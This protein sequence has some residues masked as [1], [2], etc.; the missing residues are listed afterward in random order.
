M[1]DFNGVV[2]DDEPIHLELYQKVLAPY[3]IQLTQEAYY[4][5]YLPLDSHDCL[6]QIFKDHREPCQDKMIRDLV[7][8]KNSLYDEWI[9][10]HA[11]LFPG[12][13]TFIAEAAA[14]FP[15]AIV[16]GATEN[17]IGTILTRFNL[18]KHFI[19]LI[20][21]E[22]VTQG[23]PN[24]EGLTLALQKI[25]HHLAQK[26]PAPAPIQP[27]ECC[28]IEDSIDGIQMIHTAQM[29]CLSITNSYSREKLI[30]ADLILD[31]LEKNEN[32]SPLSLILDH[33]N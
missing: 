31:S 10:T 8:Q 19:T 4:E 15:L 33:F 29:N 17:E 2:I 18:R 5:K 14:Q 20:S 13:E 7:H 25:N 32:Q 24:P 6:T 22:S 1:F 16:S 26:T 9:K 23:K 30:N 3:Q 21:A 11:K 28:V 27:N 12:V